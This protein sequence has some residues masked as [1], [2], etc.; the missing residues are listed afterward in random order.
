MGTFDQTDQQEKMMEKQQKL[1]GEIA[2]TIR[3]LVNGVEYEDDFYK[4]ILDKMVIHDKDSID[5]YLHLLPH[6]WSYAI[7]IP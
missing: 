4:E 3:E 6:R 7:A 2:E 5:V 1:I